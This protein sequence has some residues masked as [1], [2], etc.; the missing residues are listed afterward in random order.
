LADVT[1]HSFVEARGLTVGNLFDEA[2]VQVATIVQ[3]ALLRER[4]A[5]TGGDAGLGGKEI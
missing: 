5:P 1:C 2:G 3:E 4:R